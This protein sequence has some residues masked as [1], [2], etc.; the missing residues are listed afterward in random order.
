MVDGVALG[1]V[2]GGGT[3]AVAAL[4]VTTW[5]VALVREAAEVYEAID[6]CPRSDV[7]DVGNATGD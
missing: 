7:L 5:V 1:L 2:V 6:G 4:S 3:L